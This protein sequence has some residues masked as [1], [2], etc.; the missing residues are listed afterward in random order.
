MK[1]N[2]FEGSVNWMQDD[3]NQQ[4]YFK[5]Y[6]NILAKLKTNTRKTDARK[7]CCK[8]HGK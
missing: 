6:I 5:Q 8:K 7:K 2:V 4:K 3:E 1:T